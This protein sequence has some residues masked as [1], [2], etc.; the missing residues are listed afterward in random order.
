MEPH[1]TPNDLQM[2]Y[3]YLDKVTNY[4]EFG[5][6]GSTY[7]AS[8]RTNLERIVCVESDSKWINKVKESIGNDTRITYIH[9]DI[10]AV[11][12][13]WGRPGPKSTLE[14]WKK[15]SSAICDSNLPKMDFVLIDGRFRV[16]C[17]LKCFNMLDENAFIAFDD[18]LN[19]PTYHV[20]LNYFEIVEKTADKTMV[21]LKKR[22]T[23]A[24]PAELI[25]KYEKEFE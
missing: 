23:N 1:I 18:F 6:G 16:A 8:K 10:N 9:I 25:E 5:A 11:G 2:F 13:L 19:R 14:D 4:F 22:V 24:P 3:K 21:I 17:C 12:T 20:V 15:Y 7:Q